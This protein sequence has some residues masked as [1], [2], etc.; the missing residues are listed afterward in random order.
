MATVRIQAAAQLVT[1]KLRLRLW[2]TS[3]RFTTEAMLLRLEALL[4]S[5]L[6]NRYRIGVE[7]AALWRSLELELGTATVPLV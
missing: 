7:I 6:G 1:V 2:T 3:V 5:V 4:A